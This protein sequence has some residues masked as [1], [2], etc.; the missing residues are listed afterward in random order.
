MFYSRSL[1]LLLATLSLLAATS[2]R[3]QIGIQQVPD[4]YIP[5]GKTLVVPIPATDAGGAPRSYSVSIGAPTLNGQATTKGAIMGTIRTG[6]PHLS[7]GV[8]Y[9]DSSNVMQTGTMEFQLLREF[10]PITAQTIAGLTEG[11]FYS[12]AQ[13]SGN[14]KYITFYR[15]LEDALIQGGSPDNNFDGTPGFSF[16]NEYNSAL[17]F[18]GPGQLAMANDGPGD[19]T[20]GSQFFITYGPERGFDFD[21]TIF[22]QLVRGF[23]TYVGINNVAISPTPVDV[24]GNPE[25]SQPQHPVNITSATV[26]PN[27]TDALLILS[28]TGIC[29][30]VIT[31]TASN[32]S[33]STSMSFTASANDDTGNNDPPFLQPIPPKT[34]PNGVLKLALQG[35]DLQRALLIYGYQHILPLADSTATTGTSPLVSIP[36]ISNT[37]NHLNALVDQ[38]G[39]VTLREISNLEAGKGYLPDIRQFVVAAG[40]KGLQGSLAPIPAGRNGQL[41][42]PNPIATFTTGNPKDTAN[43]LDANVNWGDGTYLSGNQLTIHEVNS[44]QHRYEV[45]IPA[46]HTY[47]APGEYPVTVNV[48][49]TGGAVLTLTGTANVGAGSIAISGAD[50]YVTGGKLTNKAVATFTDTGA[51]LTAADYTATINWG[52]GAATAGTVKST[53][54]AGYEVTGSHTYK[55]PDAFTLATTVTRAGTDTATE[56]STVHVSGISSSNLFPPFVQS[57]LTQIWSAIARSNIYNA[58]SGDDGA[59]PYA[60]VVQGTDGNLYGT[61]FQGGSLGLGTVYQLTTSGSVNVLHSFT[62]GK[63]GKNPFGGLVLGTDGYLYGTAENAGTY[64]YGTI[65]QVSTTGTFNTLYEF[66][67]GSDGGYPTSALDDVN[68]YF[69]GTSTGGALGYGTIFKINP[70]G[71]F[72]LLYEFQ[73]AA[74]GGKPAGGLITG[75]D[76]LL[77]GTTALEGASSGGTVFDFNPSGTS[78]ATLYTFPPLVNGTNADGAKPLGAL[79]ESSGT[80]YGTTE[81]GGT[82]GQGTVFSIVNTGAGSTPTLLYTFTGGADGG[83]PQAGLTSGTD[84]NFYGTTESGTTPGAAGTIFQITPDGSL[85]TVYQFTGMADGGNPYGALVVGTSGELYGTTHTDGTDSAGF[86]PAGQNG[87]GTIFELPQGNAAVTPA[88]L[89]TFDGNGYQQAIDASVLVINSGNATM[90]DPNA[91]LSVYATTNGMPSGGVPLVSNGETSFPIPTLKPGQSTLIQFRME[92]TALDDRLKLPLGTDTSNRSIISALTYHDPVGDYN[93]TQKIFT[94]YLT[95][96]FNQ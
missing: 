35:T 23:D 73:G 92:G 18:S 46:A 66:T 47:T 20:D 65:F 19:D 72:S 5:S 58:A 10:T 78:P 34:A 67:G 75:T 12:P 30:S 14:T 61:T 29:Q 96:S 33:G 16:A 57:H 88:T 2:A 31:V 93:G 64:G 4:E 36:L 15:V 91:S 50:T 53:G 54:K 90:S 62:G 87:A 41:V 55:T 26:A 95:G 38:E 51:G 59:Y 85:T 45:L 52:D 79:V 43:T 22:G 44:A 86:A 37:A 69:Y 28:S 48:S 80:F 68:G 84:G 94:L 60:G 83:N 25:Y 82:N 17:I 27:N 81:T 74:D 40:E 13:V 39:G 89:H 7:L 21:Y 24:D 56:W 3:A 70:S 11:G 49:D 8:S 42:A 71:S 32:A 1:A 6:D 77:Y 63:D 9:T 76:G